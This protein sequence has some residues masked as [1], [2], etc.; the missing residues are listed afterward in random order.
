M[1]DCKTC[2]MG[3]TGSEWL[4][5]HL[6]A[7]GILVCHRL[8]NR[9]FPQETSFYEQRGS[10][11]IR[12]KSHWHILNALAMIKSLIAFMIAGLIFL[13]RLHNTMSRPAAL[14]NHDTEMNSNSTR[15]QMST[16]SQGCWRECRRS[17][18]RWPPPA[19]GETSQILCICSIK[20]SG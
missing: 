2:I 14:R 1:S 20:E 17:L 7:Y 13:G 9:V 12:L 18:T 10:T 4:L 19:N 15:I 11:L 5:F 8:C 6:P 3:N 16:S